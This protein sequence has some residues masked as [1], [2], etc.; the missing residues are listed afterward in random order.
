MK[1]SDK[2]KYV[3]SGYGIRFDSGGFWSFRN[4]NARNFII[5]GVD[6]SSSSHSDNCKNTFLILPLELT[7]ALAHQRK[8]SVLVLVKQTRNFV[9]VYIIMVIIVICLLMEKKSL[10]LKL[11]I[12]TLTFQLNFVLE[13]FL[14][15]LVLFF[16]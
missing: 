13:V 1:N 7:E 10:N 3:N 2:E 6:N 16:L 5:F 15:N 12:K 9:C 11:T 4:E 8:S 14:I